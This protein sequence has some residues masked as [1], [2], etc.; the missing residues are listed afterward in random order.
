MTSRLVLPFSD[1]GS[2]IKPPSGAKLFFFEVGTSTPKN[3]YT[4][5]SALIPNSNPVIADSVGVFSDIFITGSYKVVLKDKNDVQIW[6]ADPVEEF[7]TSE[8]VPVGITVIKNFLWQGAMQIWQRGL[9]FKPFPSREGVADGWTFARSSFDAGGVVS[10]QPGETKK[11]SLRALREFGDTS[12]R[13][14]NLVANMSRDDTLNL[15]GKTSTIKVRVKKGAGYSAVN[16]ELFLSVRYSTSNS[17]QSITAASGQ[18]SA[19]DT[20]LIS[21]TIVLMNELTE[22]TL[23]FVLPSDAKQCLFRLQYLPAGTAIAADFFEVED[24]EL[25]DFEFVSA[26]PTIPELT[27]QQALSRAR[28]QLYT[29]YPLGVAPGTKTTDGALKILSAGNSTEFNSGFNVVLPEGMRTFPSVA[30]FSPGTGIS[31]RLLNETSGSDVLA[32]AD[33]IGTSSL[34]IVPSTLGGH[35]QEGSFTPAIVGATVTHTSQIGRTTRVG[36]LRFID[37]EIDYN[38][39][40]TG[41]TSDIQ[42]TGFETAKPGTSGTFSINLQTSTGATFALTDYVVPTLFS[43]GT[44]LALTAADGTNWDYNDGKLAAAGK[45]SISGVYTVDND[46]EINEYSVHVVAEARL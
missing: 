30:L 14:F 29:S 19:S 45:L 8:S 37:I 22:H 6:E 18:Y 31:G 12:V 25:I 17:E 1:V 34:S 40:D 7:S 28:E 42:I 9:S 13:T 41:D 46:S 20:F 32:M 33:N 24:C 35:Y 23:S 4:D 16:N 26:F 39:L 21:K 15:I 44:T 10:Q 11:Y 2:G 36:N 43:A 27:Q 38:T 3:T 5:K